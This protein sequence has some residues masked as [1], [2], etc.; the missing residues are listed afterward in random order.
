MVRRF[1][2]KA[3][4]TFGVLCVGERDVEQPHDGQGDEVDGDLLPPLAPGKGHVYRVLVSLVRVRGGAGRCRRRRGVCRRRGGAAVH[5]QHRRGGRRGVAA[6]A[7][8][9]LR[10]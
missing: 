4:L 10:K 6:S 3:T 8:G 5:H 1:G 2:Q 7:V 9:H